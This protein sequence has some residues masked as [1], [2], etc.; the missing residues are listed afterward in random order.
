[1]KHLV[2]CPTNGYVYQETKST[3]KSISD[4]ITLIIDKFNCKLC[5]KKHTVTNARLT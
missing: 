2:K 4:K 3:N 5:G 1:M